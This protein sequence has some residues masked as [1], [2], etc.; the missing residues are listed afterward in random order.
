MAT[1]SVKYENMLQTGAS[2]TVKIFQATHPRAQFIQNAT[3]TA[4]GI[5][6]QNYGVAM[7]PYSLASTTPYILEAELNG[8]RYFAT[9]SAVE[10]VS[11]GSYLTM[12]TSS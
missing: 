12:S 2:T 5:A 9:Q 8:S 6:I 3:C 4:A 1:M 10:A 11:L 7:I